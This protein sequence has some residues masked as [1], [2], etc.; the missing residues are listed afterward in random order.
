M[1]MQ[2][3]LLSAI[4][5]AGCAT[6][7][8][9][10]PAPGDIVRVSS[11]RHDLVRASSTFTRIDSASV[12][13]EIDGAS[14]ELPLSEVDKLEFKTERK[15]RAGTGAAI[16]AGVGLLGMIAALSAKFGP[17]DSGENL[18]RT[19]GILQVPVTIG[20]GAL[21]GSWFHFDRWEQI[22]PPVERQAYSVLAAGR[23]TSPIPSP[24]PGD[25]VRV[26]SS[27]HD[28]VRATGIFTRIDS[29]S[30]VLEIDGTSRELRL[31]EVDKLELKTGRKSRAGTGALIG[32]GVGLLALFGA[33]VAD[34]VNEGMRSE[35]FGS[36]HEDEEKWIGVIGL[37]AVP[38]GASIGALIGSQFHSDRWEQIYL[39]R[40]EEGVYQRLLGG[41]SNGADALAFR[42]VSSVRTLRRG[43]GE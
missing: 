12:V 38:V 32:V 19:A 8:M 26:S 36:S 43:A 25:I 13:L 40:R 39:P 22:H 3:F 18:C 33:L 1:K 28:P 30:V 11:S 5:A 37:L 35:L 14:R 7:P 23:A 24:A 6:S 10:P 21:I 34:A 17:Y 2:W 4:F 31:S 27:R 16:G 20:L 15:S 9:P 42:Q 41:N 29:A